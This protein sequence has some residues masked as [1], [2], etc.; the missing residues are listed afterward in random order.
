MRG[1]VIVAVVAVAA[2]C[3]HDAAPAKSGDPDSGS[4]GASDALGPPGLRITTS[5]ESDARVKAAF[6]TGPASEDA[7][8]QLGTAPPPP[9]IGVPQ[10]DSAWIATIVPPPGATTDTVK[11]ALPAH[12][13]AAHTVMGKS[14]GRWL[15]VEDARKDRPAIDELA[16]VVALI[17]VDDTIT[18]PQLEREEVWANAA[19]KALGAA[20]P[21]FAM[22]PAQ[23]ADKA[24]AAVAMRD[25]LHDD[26]DVGVAVV[27]PTGKQIPAKLAWDALYSAGF[28]W[29]DGDYFHWVPSA[30]TDDSQGIE[31]GATSG[32]G[33]FV[34]EKLEPID[35]VEMS[36]DV[37]RTWHPAEMFEVMVRAAQYLAKRFGGT[38]VTTD[39]KPF[40]AA[41]AKRRMD[42]IVAQLTAAGVTPG[43]ELALAAFD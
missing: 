6:P 39:G 12:T 38:V 24:T 3:K 7:R 27:G 20:P 37:A 31:L 29:G 15:F 19:A 42:T 10:P 8:A 32:T 16:I 9:D 35:G 1:A 36:F 23:A 11:K 14:A 26:L 41:A 5:D 30:D 18:A 28:T 21:T 25:K 34:P 43:S 13:G 2:G 40:D 17:D 33:Y 4:A 22:T